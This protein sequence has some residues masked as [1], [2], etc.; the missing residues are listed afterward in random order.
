MPNPIDHK[1]WAEGF[2]H[3]YAGFVIRHTRADREFAAGYAAGK[4]LRQ[5]HQDEYQRGLESGRVAPAKGTP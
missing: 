1:V 4:Q 2:R 3:G 5:A